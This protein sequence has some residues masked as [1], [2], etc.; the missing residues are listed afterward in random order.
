LKDEWRALEVGISLRASSM[1]GSWRKDTF[2]GDSEGY[3]EFPER[4]RFWGTRRDVP[5][6]GPLRE[7]GGG[8]FIQRNIYEEFERY[9]KRPHKQAALSIGATVGEPG[10]AF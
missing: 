6:L 5:F 9:V 4:P 2:T 3:V 10:G 1:R 8:F 7:A